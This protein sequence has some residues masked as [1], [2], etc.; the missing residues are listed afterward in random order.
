VKLLLFPETPKISVETP[1]VEE[2]PKKSQ[3][4]P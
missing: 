4:F 1:E 2:I 3:E